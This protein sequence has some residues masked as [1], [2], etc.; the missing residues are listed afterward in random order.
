M[1]F[2]DIDLFTLTKAII[3]A[4]WTKSV[5]RNQDGSLEWYGETGYPT[6]EQIQAELDKLT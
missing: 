4:G 1:N 3:A 6:T 5:N 2:I